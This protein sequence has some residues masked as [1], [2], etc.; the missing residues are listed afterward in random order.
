MPKKVSAFSGLQYNCFTKYAFS[1]ENEF[2]SVGRS[3]QNEDP[4]VVE[5]IRILLLRLSLTCGPQHTNAFSLPLIKCSAAVL[6]ASDY[7]QVVEYS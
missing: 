2:S 5:N 4:T 6:P 1:N 7:D 3:K